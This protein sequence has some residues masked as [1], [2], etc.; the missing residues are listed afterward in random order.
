MLRLADREA[1]DGVAVK[2]DIGERAG[3]LRAQN[4]IVA[5][6]YDAEQRAAGRR[7]LEGALAALRP[8]ERQPHGAIELSLA[9]RQ[10]DALVEL[11]D[12]V[13]AE[14]RLDFDG[15]LWRQVDHGAIDMRAKG[16]ALGFVDGAQL[17]QRHHL[18]TAESV[19]IGRGQF[20]NLCRPPS[21]AI[22]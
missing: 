13:G 21:P 16:N 1:A 14:Q 20:M 10:L 19:R 17:R 4:G 18:E 3:A 22:R 5:A 9:A 8:C 2:S 6:L 15:T 11:H 12:D 7:S